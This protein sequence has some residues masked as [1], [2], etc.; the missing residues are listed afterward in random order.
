MNNLLHS[1]KNGNVNV[2]LFSDG[3]SIREY[4]GEPN[5]DYPCSMDIKITDKCNAGCRFCHEQS[6]PEGQHGDLD[7]LLDVL[8]V[9]PA[10]AELAI[11][12]GAPQQHPQLLPFLQELK[13]RGLVANMTINQK[14]FKSDHSII[15][16]MIQDDLVKGIGCSFNTKQYLP[17][18]LPVLKATDNLVFH[19]IMGIN[20][21]SDIELLYNFCRENNKKC[22][23]LILGYKQ[24]GFGL[25]YY[26]KNKN[27]EDN[28]YQWFIK[29]AK[30]FKKKDLVLSFDNLAIDQL[31]LKR[32]FTDEGWD[33]FFMGKDGI[34]T[35]Y[36]DAVKQQYAKSSTT[37]NRESFNDMGLLEFFKGLRG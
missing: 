22:K 17:D 24:Y 10:G 31:N 3:T 30:Y 1:Y 5:P 15:M 36:I 19:V 34:F 11:G 12:G 4:E 23:I 28:K 21:V 33:K 25:N 29:L 18:I 32:Y 26:L 16:K 7:K 9:I 20:P 2:S 14:H 6:T 37:P 35:M 8:K 27:I 13:S